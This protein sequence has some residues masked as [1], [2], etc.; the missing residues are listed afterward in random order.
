MVTR[1]RVSSFFPR[2]TIMFHDIEESAHSYRRKNLK[3]GWP[4]A[5]DDVI[6]QWIGKYVVIKAWIILAVEFG[7]NK[8][9]WT[10]SPRTGN[11]EVETKWV[12]LDLSHRSKM[13][14]NC[15]VSYNV[16]SRC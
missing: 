7:V 3:D 13:Q 6:G 8:T 14:C 15:L 11:I 5:R 10:D 1:S 2:H 9:Y 12:I 4:R 16:V